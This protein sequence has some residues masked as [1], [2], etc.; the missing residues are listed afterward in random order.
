[1]DIAFRGQNVE[2]PDAVRQA[3]SE[4]V[5]RLSR[6]L[7]G[8]DRAEVWFSEERNPR[9]SEREAS[10]YTPGPKNALR[11]ASD[12]TKESVNLRLR[13]STTQGIY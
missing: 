4:K 6:Y 5:T 12:D 7:E 11:S 9:I 3:V 2:I 10:S 8:M 13:S 1:M